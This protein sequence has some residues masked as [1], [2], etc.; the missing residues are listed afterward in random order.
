MGESTGS[1]T[2]LAIDKYLGEP[3]EWADGGGP[4][5]ATRSRTRLICTRGARTSTVARQG[6][7]SRWPVPSS[8]GQTS[9]VNSGRRCRG[10]EFQ[11]AQPEISRRKSGRILWLVAPDIS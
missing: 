1:V 6:R 11:A 2:Q 7:E 4:C 9:E 10:A 5:L 8:A 3:E